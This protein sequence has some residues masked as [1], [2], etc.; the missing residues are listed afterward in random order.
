[1]ASKITDISDFVIHKSQIKL[2][3]TIIGKGGFANVQLGTYTRSTGEIEVAAKLVRSIQTQE[4]QVMKELNHS[5]VITF[6]GVLEDNPDTYIIMELAEHRD[7]RHYLDA[8]KSE[9]KSL[10]PLQ[11]VWKWVFEAASGLNYLHGIHHTHRDIKSLNYLVTKDFTIKLGDL[12]L[13]T[14]MDRTQETSGVRGT[15]RWMAPEVIK[16]QKRSIKSDVF[17]VWHCYMGSSV[18]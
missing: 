5:N 7:L 18:H 9:K 2:S 11:V 12:G 3:G 13:A 6:Y 4:I 17:L 16:E 10:L 1:M 15:C 8:W 14:E